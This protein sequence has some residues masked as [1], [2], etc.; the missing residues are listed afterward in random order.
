MVLGI[1]CFKYSVESRRVM[2]LMHLFKKWFKKY[3]CLRV[4]INNHFVSKTVL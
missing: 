1:P 4:I 2:M 3:K